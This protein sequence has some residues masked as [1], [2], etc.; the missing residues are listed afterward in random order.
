[1]K[2]IDRSQV[3]AVV[4]ATLSIVV[5]VGVPRPYSLYLF[6]A[7]LGAALVLW[8]LSIW[9]RIQQGGTMA[10]ESKAEAITT[11]GLTIVFF[12]AGWLV[13]FLLED[14]AAAWL[15]G[16]M[17]AIA[18]FIVALAPLRKPPPRPPDSLPSDE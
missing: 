5:F 13:G 9:L 17:A 6:W 1:V 8:L 3:A 10:E 18:G 4:L 7:M 11:V 2:I 12:V 15:F 16:F 14:Y